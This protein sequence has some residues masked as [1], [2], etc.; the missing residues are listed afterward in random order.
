MLFTRDGR[1]MP[2][3]DMY[4]GHSAFLICSGP[5]L[6]SHD[7][8][9]LS[10]RGVLTCAVNNA[11]TIHR[12]HFWISVDSPGN[13]SDTIWTDPGIVKFVPSCHMEKHY[14]VRDEYDELAP[15]RQV[16]GE[17]PAVFGF[18]RNA[19]FCA[20]QWLYEDTFNWGNRSDLI[21]A[22]G[23]KGSRSVMYVALRLLFYLGLRKVFLL[24][25]DF[26][27][28]S[29]E[30]NYAFE[31]ARS[32]SSVRNNNSAYRILNSRLKHLK[33]LF[34]NEG[35]EVINCTPDSGL[36]VFP[37][38]SYEQALEVSKSG[39]PKQIITEGM[40]D[41]D[42]RMRMQQAG[43]LNASP[44]SLPD[45]TLVTAVDRRNVGCFELAWQTWMKFRPALR[46]VPTIIIH[47]PDLDPSEIRRVVANKSDVRLVCR[48][49]GKAACE[50]DRWSHAFVQVP[51]DHVTTPWYLKLEVE[52][53]ACRQHVW[54]TDEWFTPDSDGNLP[55]F[56]ASP[57]GYTKPS[58]T[59]HRL[60]DWADAVPGLSKFRRLD[61]PYNLR[62]KRIRHVTAS[63]W[64]YFGNTSWTKEIAE[65][66]PDRL[67]CSAHDTFMVYCA[68]RRGD[69]FLLRKMKNYGWDHSFSQ[70][71]QERFA[72]RC[73]ELL[74]DDIAGAPYPDQNNR[75]TVP[76]TECGKLP[77]NH[78][79]S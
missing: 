20:E 75:E 22:Y 65:Y 56:V 32:P 69:R 31:Q 46:E 28:E 66:A 1:V 45:M 47:G 53:V 68:T 8:S 11:A 19:V 58:D 73:R 7:L 16:V 34:D 79:S 18:R 27:M 71:Y 70:Q 42:K 38:M 24:G 21:D 54:A 51:A 55:S 12:P 49:P 14:C 9:E 6:V 5:S 25:C 23:N 52:A 61:L 50:R 41:R 39:T 48:Q 15:S 35:F 29:G 4:Q 67:P 57:W 26:R 63:T 13:F 17:M 60:D 59:I 64:C 36:T 62:E 78:H 76:P 43:E 77:S 74:S 3:L 72:A 10:E 37:A 40:Y 33:P 2:F 44:T 30:N